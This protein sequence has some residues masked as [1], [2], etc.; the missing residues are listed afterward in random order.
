MPESKQSEARPHLRNGRKLNRLP[1]ASDVLASQ[2]RGR[3]LGDRLEPGTPLLSESALIEHSRFSRSTVRETLRLLES[4]GL[5][6]IRR[7]PGGGIFASRPDPSSISRSLASL[8]TVCD[9]SLRQLFEF[10]KLLEPEAAAMAAARCSEPLRESLLDAAQQPLAAHTDSI[11]DFHALLADGTGN[12]LFRILMSTLE[13]V[14]R[15]HVKAE[16]VTAEQLQ[17]TRRAHI[18]IAEAIREGDESAA[19]KY[20]L[21][22]L[23]SFEKVM[24]AQGRLDQPIVPTSEWTRTA[25]F[26]R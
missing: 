21:Q 6:E 20:M 23:E 24:E 22:H 11:V 1:K 15:V 5:I 3:I 12:E 2:L 4:E 25:S 14:V 26:L 13:E 17:E 8:L 19:R 10:R 7:G 18:K 9:A 16:D